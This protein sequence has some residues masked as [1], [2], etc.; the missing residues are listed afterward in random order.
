MLGRGFAQA[1]LLWR[2][3]R[4]GLPH[5]PEYFAALAAFAAGAFFLS[6][7]YAY[8]LFWFLAVTEF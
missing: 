1:Y 2:R 4:K 6:S 8:P 5:M 3:R 7:A